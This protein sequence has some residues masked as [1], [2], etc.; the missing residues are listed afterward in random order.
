MPWRDANSMGSPV[1]LPSI[2]TSGRDHAGYS[3]Q[4]T[5]AETSGETS[6]IY[7]TERGHVDWPWPSQEVH[8]FSKAVGSQAKE[9]QAASTRAAAVSASATWTSGAIAKRIS[10]SRKSHLFIVR[11]C[12]KKHYISLYM[13]PCVC[14]CTV[15]G[16]RYPR[17]RPWHLWQKSICSWLATSVHHTLVQWRSWD[18]KDLLDLSRSLS[19]CKL[20]WHLVTS[21]HCHKFFRWKDYCHSKPLRIQNLGITALRHQPTGTRVSV[22]RVPVLSKRQCVSCAGGRKGRVTEKTVHNS[23]FVT[24][25]TLVQLVS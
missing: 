24:C 14:A 6:V 8:H 16:S 10:R 7:K 5:D 2:S 20:S 13:G 3:S 4:V 11:F 1:S 19:R 15:R 23:W 25:K 21:L 22:V 18:A 17:L 9:W 12:Q